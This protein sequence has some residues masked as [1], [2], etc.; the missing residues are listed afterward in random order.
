M[1]AWL[2]VHAFICIFVSPWVNHVCACVFRLCSASVTSV[3]HFHTSNPH[4]L[5]CCR[6]TLTSQWHS[7]SVVSLTICELCYMVAGTNTTLLHA[8]THTPCFTCT[9]CEVHLTHIFMF[10][11]VTLCHWHFTHTPYN[12]HIFTR[13]FVVPLRSCLRTGTFAFRNA[14][15]MAQG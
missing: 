11:I 6:V 14:G 13:Q 3:R 7:L 8:H 5:F 9:V 4:S 10:S 2:T 15:Q 12:H 1:Y